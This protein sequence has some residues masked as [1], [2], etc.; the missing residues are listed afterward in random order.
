MSEKSYTAA[1]IELLE[2]ISGSMVS[3]LLRTFSIHHENDGPVFAEDLTMSVIAT[4]VCSLLYNSLKPFDI[5][6]ELQ[7]QELLESRYAHLKVRLQNAIESGFESAT[8]AYSGKHTDYY[9][10]IK[11]TP[12]PIN[13]LPC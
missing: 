1:E 8:T 3:E 13:E 9:C 5:P 4:L 2:E 12:K 7:T 11:Q 6:V 10:L